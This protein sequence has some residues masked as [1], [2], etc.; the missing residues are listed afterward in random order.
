M[1]GC[2]LDRQLKFESVRSRGCMLLIGRLMLRAV[3]VVVIGST[4]VVVAVKVELPSPEFLCVRLD[5]EVSTLHL[6][7]SGESATS[8]G[9]VGEGPRCAKS[10]LVIGLFEACAL[11][12]AS[13]LLL[14]L[15]TSL[16]IHSMEQ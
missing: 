1:G 13:Q 2:A 8:S 6:R 5:R 16:Q 15:P 11:S 12:H 9:T 4:C 10:L 3:A 7:L 14:D